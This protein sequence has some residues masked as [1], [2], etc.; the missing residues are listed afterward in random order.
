MI[1]EL[2]S[3]ILSTKRGKVCP[4]LEE[5]RPAQREEWHRGGVLT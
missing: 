3:P 1:W 5:V 2:P 4:G